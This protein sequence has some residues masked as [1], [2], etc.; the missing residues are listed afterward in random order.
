MAKTEEISKPSFLDLQSHMCK[1]PIGDPQESD[2]FFCGTT[3]LEGT[4]YCI[5]HCGI[6]YRPAEERRYASFR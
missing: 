5:E 1:F 3:R 4:P 2:F 6:A